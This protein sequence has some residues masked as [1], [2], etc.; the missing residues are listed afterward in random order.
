MNKLKKILEDLTGSVD[1][2]HPTIEIAIDTSSEKT[3]IS[4]SKKRRK[5]EK[6]ERREPEP[7]E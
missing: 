7:R 3:T 2:K 5:K 1:I 6:K 4:F